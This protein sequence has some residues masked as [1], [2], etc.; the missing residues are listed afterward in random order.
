MCRTS[1][2]GQLIGEGALWLVST[3]TMF[4]EQGIDLFNQSTISTSLNAIDLHFCKKLGSY[5]S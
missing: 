3:H 2:L 5:S 4:D 1:D